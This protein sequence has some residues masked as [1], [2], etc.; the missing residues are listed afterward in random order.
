MQEFDFDK[1]VAHL[2]AGSWWCSPPKRSLVW[3]QM[4]GMMGLAKIYDAK[5]RP[6]FN[7]LIVHIADIHQAQNLVSSGM[8]GHKNWRRRF[9]LG[10]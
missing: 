4:Q 5:G 6:S 2:R 9:G 10:L 3:A 1:A 7:P 8:I